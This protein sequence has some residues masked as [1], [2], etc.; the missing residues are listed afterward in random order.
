MKPFFVLFLSHGSYTTH[1]SIVTYV[2]KICLTT[3]SGFPSRGNPQCFGRERRER[4][5]HEGGRADPAREI[6][7]SPRH[8]RPRC[9]PA[10]V[11]R[12]LCLPHPAGAALPP[13]GP[14]QGRQGQRGGLA[15]HPPQE[16]R[17]GGAAAGGGG[18]GEPGRRGAGA[19][20][21]RGGS[22][23]D[24]AANAAGG[25]LPILDIE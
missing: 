8:C 14:R 3:V 21:G 24:A 1:E 22:G 2:N 9:S 4:S 7:N 17:P 16:V 10:A 18:G 19:A 15:P 23:R 25:M 13:H 20:A 12:V 5:D 11:L 6:N